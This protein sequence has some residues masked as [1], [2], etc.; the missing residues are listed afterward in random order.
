MVIGVFFY[1]L[2]LQKLPQI[3]VL[4]AIGATNWYVLRQLLVQALLVSLAAVAIAVPLSLLTQ[5][6][7][8][9]SPDAVPIAFTPGT[10][11]VTAVALMAA[12]LVGSIVSARRVLSVDPIIALG[13][14]Q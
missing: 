2:T 5:R 12:A 3:G 8:A 4:K 10:I 9:R 14:Q 11:V 6:L 1:V 7:L 13:Q